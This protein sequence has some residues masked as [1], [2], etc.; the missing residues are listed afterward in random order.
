[1]TPQRVLLISN[2]PIGRH[3]AGPAIRYY[4]LARELG[5]HFDVTLMV[6]EPVNIEIEN[7]RIVESQ[8]Y[9]AHAFRGYAESFDALIA[10]NLRPWTMRALGKSPVRVIYDLYDPFLV[11]NLALFGGQESWSRYKNAV[12]RANSLAQEVAL[13][14]GDA[15]LCASE[16]QRDFWLGILGSLG[17]LN[18]DEHQRDPSL[19]RLI[20]VVPFGLPPDRPVK[21]EPVLKGVVPGIGTADRV[22]LWGGGIWNWFDPLTVIQA[23]ARLAERRN[24]VKLY[25]LGVQHPNPETEEMGMEQKAVEQAKRLGVY[26]RS[27]FFNFSW[28]PYEDRGNFLLEADLGVSAH[29]DDIETRFAF[30]TRILDYLWA[31]LPIV[32][33]KGDVLSELVSERNLG[34]VVGHGDVEAWMSAIE[35][36]LDN[37]RQYETTKHN[38]A[39]AR[40]DYEWPNA[41]NP[42]VELISA[43]DQTWSSAR[44]S[45]GMVAR[46]VWLSAIAAV[47]KRG[48]RAALS[49]ALQIVRK[50]RVP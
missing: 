46:Y 44:S 35:Q 42:L 47:I 40:S 20:D 10:Q 37:P 19:R 4:N 16:R 21:T 9:G 13:A 39:R 45:A 43:P 1:M 18:R 8:T 41:I 12:L 5:K 11:E 7:I 38:I 49:C 31:D 23:V 17:R 33:T 50:P 36:L 28:I 2:H 34:C 15:F 27:V 22:L 26:E 30:R 14:S 3:M 48:F 6:P 24:D 32:T 25:F 29:F